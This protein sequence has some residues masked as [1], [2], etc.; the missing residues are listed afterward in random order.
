[1]TAL[2]DVG[3]LVYVIHAIKHEEYDQQH[4]NQPGKNQ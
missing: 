2:R 3:M 1:M 4:A